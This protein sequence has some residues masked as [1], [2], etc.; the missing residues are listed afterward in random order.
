METER[1][2]VVVVASRKRPPKKSKKTKSQQAAAKEWDEEQLLTASL[3]GSGGGRDVVQNGRS[4]LHRNVSN[5]N[6]SNKRPKKS[7]LPQRNEAALE[8]AFE[9]DRVG[10][11]A[12]TN[13]PRDETSVRGESDDH[14]ESSS[15]S[16]RGDNVESAAAVAAATAAWVDDDDDDVAVNLVL[17]GHSSRLRKLRT[18]RTETEAV[19]G[20]DLQD[21]LRGRFASTTQMTA[22]T[23]WAEVVTTT[24]NTPTTAHRRKK[25]DDDDDDDNFQSSSSVPFLVASGLGG[26][27]RLPP[28]VL[29]LKRCPDVNLADPN[30]AVVQAVHFHPGSD[31]D[32][33]LVLTAGL[34]KSLRFFQAK[35]EGSVKIHG[36]H[37]KR[38]SYCILYP[39][40]VVWILV[41]VTCKSR[42][43]RCNSFSFP[44]IGTHSRQTQKQKLAV[45]NLPIYSASFLGT[46]GNVVVTGRRPFFYLYDSVAGKVDMVPRI[47][48]RDEKSLERCVVSPDGRTLAFCGNDGYV[49]LFDAYHKAWMADYKLNGSVRT[50]AFTPDNAEILAS[51]SDGEVYRWDLRSKKCLERFANQDGTITSCLAV[52][53]RNL[54]VGAESGVVNLY[55]EQQQQQRMGAKST[56]RTPT[57]SIFNLKTSVDALRF[58]GDGQILAMSSRRETRALKLL[59][60]PTQTVFANWPTSNTPLGYVWSMD[61]SPSSKY[62][63][64]GNDK[65]KCLLYKLMHYDRDE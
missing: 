46:T 59:H 60:V 55:S 39:F 4:H 27:G 23:D 20:T 11:T 19:R 36:I 26:S 65:G 12:T 51:G 58:N 50:M 42:N 29:N 33:P 49:I 54:A 31:P 35:D 64:M 56:S 3:F 18:R 30:R 21:R 17:P 43:S 52:T 6:S 16:S 25:G 37:C 5:S 63:A 24:E 9:I 7:S 14:D 1:P 34:D 38:L 53:N 15:S 61:F 44:P 2:G 28:H 62:L 32:Q 8:F 45:P 13:A 22:R 41:P 10:D 48:G 57:K 47:V 40:R